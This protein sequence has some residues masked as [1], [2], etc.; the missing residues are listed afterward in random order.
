MTWSTTRRPAVD[1]RAIRRAFWLTGRV[2]AA[3]GKVRHGAVGVDG[4]RGLDDGLLAVVVMLIAG[5][6]LSSGE[7]DAGYR[8]AIGQRTDRGGQGHVDLVVQRVFGGAV[9]DE[10]DGGG[11]DRRDGRESS[12]EFLAQSHGFPGAF[13]L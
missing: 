6:P 2:T 10:T 12:D 4:L 7:R 5:R 13:R 8:T 9:G 1:P 11:H 3:P